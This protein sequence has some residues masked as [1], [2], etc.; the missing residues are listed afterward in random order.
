[1][2]KVGYFVLCF[3]P[4]VCM[5]A[6]NVGVSMVLMIVKA[7]QYLS[8]GGSVGTYTDYIMSLTTNSDFLLNA[9]VI[10]QVIALIAAAIIY[11]FAF[12]EKTIE[13]PVNVFGN[14]GAVWVIILFVGTELL[15][16]CALMKAYDIFPNTMEAYSDMI[17]KSGLSELTLISTI[18]TLVLAPIAEELVFRGMTFKLAR[19]LTK[20]FWVANIIQAAMFGIAH[21][22]IVQGIYAGILGLFLGYIYKK[23]NSLM[24]SMLAHLTFNFC[25]TYLV[26]LLFGTE[27][28]VPTVKMMIVFVMALILIALGIVLVEKD[29]KSKEREKMF[30][31][32]CEKERLP[33]V[34][35]VY[36]AY[37]EGYVPSENVNPSSIVNNVDSIT[38][39][40]NADD[41]SENKE[42]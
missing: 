14:T 4:M 15:A 40:N 41:N 16:S 42:N 28:N 1:M 11:Y 2:K 3:V 8:N 30:F 31:E 18:A 20:S 13:N 6:I 34:Q 38:V 27:E 29:K 12:K 17:E 35:P 21:L 33:K 36:Y 5:L 24:A 7:V 37:P 22:N 25:G 32:R 26:A 10:Y 9:T 23:Y 19:K 39:Q